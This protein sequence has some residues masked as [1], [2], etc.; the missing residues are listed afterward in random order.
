MKQSDLDLML[1][2][3]NL[4]SMMLKAGEKKLFGLMEQKMIYYD[5]L[6]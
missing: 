5:F 3:A 2:F 4:I 6:A 1:W